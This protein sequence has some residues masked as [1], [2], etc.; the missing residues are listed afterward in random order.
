MNDPS[1]IHQINEKVALDSCNA[2]NEIIE[3][4]KHP[5]EVSNSL[6]LQILRD[7]RDTEYGM[8]YG[9]GNIETVEEYQKNVPVVTYADISPF[10]EKME[11]GEKNVLTAYEC[12]HFNQTSGTVGAPKAIPMS[13]RQTQVFIKYDY[14]W[15]N[16]LLYKNLD[17]SY[18]DGR[19]FATSEGTCRKLD[20]GLTIG[21]ASAKM[22][23]FV[24][25]GKD[26]A[27]KRLRLTYTSP[28]E[29]T[30]PQPHTN[31]KYIHTRFALMDKE[32]TGI[33]SGFYSVL[34]H[35]LTYIA[36]NYE[37]LI[38]DIERGT[39]DESVEMPDET[40]RSLLSKIEP[41]PERAAE[42]REIFRN[43]SDIKFVPLVWPK[44]QYI[45]G[46][47]TDGFSIYR[48]TLVNSFAGDGITLFLSGINASEGLWSISSGPDDPSGILASGS[49]FMEFLPVDADDDLS[50][51]VTIDKLEIGK[52]YELVIT[53]LSGL[54]RYRMGDAVLV[55][56]MYNSAP[57]VEFMYRVNKTISIICEKT[58]ETAVEQT[59]EKSCEELGISFNDYCVYADQQSVPGRYR[60]YIESSDKKRSIIDR[61]KLEN[62]VLRHLIEANPRFEVP[63]KKGDILSPS[64]EFLQP[65]TH[66]LWRDLC[67]YNGASAAQIKP[68]RVMKENEYRFFS[69]L[70]EK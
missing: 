9:F 19:V 69:N 23:D 12:S 58:T 55:T 65:E 29:A 62:A 21:C 39:I 52:I 60:F 57:K 30:C 66:L 63:Y 37:M 68:V 53:N 35:L 40:R 32:I 26:A 24:Q 50:K 28:I 59:V 17:P 14:L 6:L 33:V 54:Y 49:A 4:T 27:D 42:L 13:D 16:Y 5:A 70:V 45:K 31:T 7:N 64:V 11:A 15:G 1:V 2:A 38:N 51:I 44:L 56:G 67:V 10:V 41:M 46:V 20:S 36:D 22:A 8:K 3:E 61:S 47:G 18:M 25:G 34:V 48:D 43:G